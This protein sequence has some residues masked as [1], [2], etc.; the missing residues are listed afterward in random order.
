[1]LHGLWIPF[2]SVKLEDYAIYE[3]ILNMVLANFDSE[4]ELRHYILGYFNSRIE[5][6]P[7]KT[8]D[9]KLKKI[10]DKWKLISL[11]D[12][13]HPISKE[14]THKRGEYRARIDHAITTQN[15]IS[16]VNECIII[17]H[18]DDFSDHK[19]IAFSLKCEKDNETQRKESK[20]FHKFHWKN[21]L[22]REEYKFYQN[23]Y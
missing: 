21:L 19:A 4:K 11:F 6:S 8:Y 14:Y 7:N 2:H 18:Q 15:S 1:M 16:H 20:L 17:N 13:F 9:I 3:R 5:M 23:S 22:F 12:H 10:I